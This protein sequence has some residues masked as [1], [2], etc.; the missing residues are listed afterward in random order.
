MELNQCSLF[1]LDIE[2]LRDISSL[3]LCIKESLRIDPPFKMT[4]TLS[5]IDPVESHGI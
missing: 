1:N 5:L 4:A 3:N 2:I